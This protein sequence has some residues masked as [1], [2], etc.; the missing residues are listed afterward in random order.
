MLN[1]AYSHQFHVVELAIPSLPRLAKKAL[2]DGPPWSGRRGT[3][4][5]SRVCPTTMRRPILRNQQEQARPTSTPTPR[6]YYSSPSPQPERLA[7]SSSSSSAPAPRLAASARASY[8][9]FLSFHDTLK[10]QIGWAWRGLVDGSRWDV[11]VS[12]MTRHVVL[13]LVLALLHTAPF[14]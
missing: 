4:R 11:V 14:F 1:I 8:P 10:L 5:R 13:V 12:L 3:P 2:C 6:G 7:A 9:V